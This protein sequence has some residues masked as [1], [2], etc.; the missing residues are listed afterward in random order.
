MQTS[1]MLIFPDI[2]V[3]NGV[4]PTLRP[5]DTKLCA[6]VISLCENITT[7]H[8]SPSQIQ[9]Y[10]PSLQNL[11]S[12]KNMRIN[13]HLSTD[14]TAMLVQIQGIKDLTLDNA[15]WQVISALPKWAA[16]KLSPS[17]TSLTL[18]VKNESTSKCAIAD[19]M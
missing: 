5:H 9:A 18:Y 15:S 2:T 19:D 17:L 6:E 7:F 1:F 16:E 4:K 13:A 3:F 8:C 12:L 10:L 11:R 14:Q